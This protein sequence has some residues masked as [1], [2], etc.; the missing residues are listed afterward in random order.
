MTIPP[1][2][3]R[4]IRRVLHVVGWN[5]ILL[6]VG[7]ALLA[8]AGEAYFRLTV[9]FIKSVRHKEF[10]PKVGFVLQPGSEVRHTN[11]LDFWTISRVNSLGFLDREP[12]PPERT[13]ASCHVAMIGDSFVEASHVSINDKFHVQL[14][15]LAARELPHLN[16]TTSAFGIEDTG[17]I[18]QLPLYD[19]YARLLRPKLLVLVFVYNDLRNNSPILHVLRS[20]WDPKYPPYPSVERNLDGTIKMLPPHPDHAKFG[21]P[22]QSVPESWGVRVTRN[23]KEISYFANWLDVKK[24]FPSPAFHPAQLIRRLEGLSQRPDYAALLEGWRRIPEL[25]RHGWGAIVKWPP[26]IEDGLDFT[27]FALEQ[28]KKRTDRDGVRLIILASSRRAQYL[29][30]RMSEMAATS[31]IPVIDQRDYIRRQRD[32]R[33][34]AYFRHDL[35]WNVAGHRWAAETLLE[36]LKDNQEVCDAGSANAGN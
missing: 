36:W 17:Q 16:V 15:E 4:R 2:P 3:P 13:A 8:I 26:L 24:M 29:F 33:S 9:P 12:L 23:L 25:S 7:V 14:E 30:D 21:S 1:S 31:G 6:V 18:H 27:A 5:A 34:D 19:E 10:V 35:H 32:K 22:R 20:G 11:H 28:F